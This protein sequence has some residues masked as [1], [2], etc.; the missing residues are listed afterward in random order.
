MRT[1]SRY[2][3][4]YCT[5]NDNHSMDGGFLYGE[6]YSMVTIKHSKIY[7]NSAEDTGSV[8]YLLSCVNA[9]AFVNNTI[10][11]NEVG[12]YGTIYLLESNLV[13]N[14]TIF[15]D[16]VESNE[17]GNGITA[18]IMGILSMINV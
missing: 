7:R 9:S 15:H 3:C 8:M 4:E 16:N 10:Y 11:N 14:D 18:G 13:M 2:S 17:G 1:F 5:I 12:E 6:I